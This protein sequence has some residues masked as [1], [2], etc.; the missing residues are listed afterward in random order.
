M[1]SIEQLSDVVIVMI[2]DIVTLT[3]VVST[4]GHAFTHIQTLKKKYLS[5][6]LIYIL[7]VAH[8][9]LTIFHILCL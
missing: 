8:K 7:F 2:Y 5:S 1:Y 6:L 3:Q 9:L 4:P